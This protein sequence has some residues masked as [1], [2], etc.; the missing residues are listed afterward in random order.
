MHHIADIIILAIISIALGVK[1]FSILGEKRDDPTAAN[2][3]KHSN[4]HFSGKAKDAESDIFSKS[5]SPTMKDVEIILDESLSGEDTLKILDPSF[6]KSTFL[7]NASSAFKMVLDA[8]AKGDNRV[9]SDLLNIEMMRKFVY[10]I[11]KR[12]EKNLTCEINIVKIT[13]SEIQEIT[14]EGSIINIKVKISPEIIAYIKDENNKVIS[15]HNEKIE[16]K[17]YI[18]EFS[19]N[20]KSPDPTW[21]LVNL[22]NMVL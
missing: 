17:K 5:E 19:R 3:R 2:K 6:D 11:S 18:W 14:S 1:L 22:D 4:N 8:Y 15:G 12:E 10:E 7:S 9:L 16:K 13:K 21:Q 20:L